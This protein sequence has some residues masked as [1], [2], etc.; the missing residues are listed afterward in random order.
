MKAKGQGRL[1]SMFRFIV[2]R[3]WWIVAFYSLLLPPSVY[4]ALRVEQ[5][6]S[7]D[8]LIVRSDPDYV[9]NKEF[10]EVFGSGEYVLLLAEAEDPFAPAVL[11]R[12]D[13]IERRLQG[14]P[15]VEA[16]SALTVYRRMAGGGFE[17][18]SG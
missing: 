18:T 6:N 12:I 16:S 9:A 5:D 7:L 4:F 14:L 15:G 17:A 3:R 10:E 13:E 11:R 1:E 8:R 2:A